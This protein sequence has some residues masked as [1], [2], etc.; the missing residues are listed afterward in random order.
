MC[1]NS[2][3]IM[4]FDFWMENWILLSK[5]IISNVEWWKRH[6]KVEWL[7]LDAL[8]NLCLNAIFHLR[9]VAINS[10][11]GSSVCGLMFDIHLSFK[12][13]DLT[14]LSSSALTKLY[15]IIHNLFCFSQFFVQKF[16][17]FLFFVCYFIFK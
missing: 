1:I 9:F 8:L 5:F 3:D 16:L 4:A 2:L 10:E 14:C 12:K 11:F 13:L 15:A 17:L 6:K 7:S